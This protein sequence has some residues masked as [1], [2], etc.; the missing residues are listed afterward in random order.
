LKQKAQTDRVDIV[1]FGASGDLTSR[2]LVPALHTLASEKGLPKSVNI[3]GVGRSKF[4]DKQ[5]QN[6]LYKHLKENPRSNPNICR[7]PEFANTISYLAGSYDD[8]STYR[9]LTDKLIHLDQGFEEKGNYLFYLATPPILYS[10]IVEHLGDAGLNQSKSGW[11]RIIIEKPF[12]RD[13]QSAEDLNRQVHHVF[14]EDQVYRID[15]YLGKETVQNILAFR[16]GNAIFEPLWNRNYVDHVQITVTETVGIEHRAGYYD[17][18]GVVRD[19]FQSH[20]LQLVTIIAM[21]PPAAMKERELRDEKVKVLQNLRLAALDD[22]VLGQYRG[23]VNEPGVSQSSKTPTYVS[24]KLYIDNWRWQGVPFYLR[25]GKALAQKATEVILQF[26]RVPSIMFP[27]NNDLN[28]N[29]IS[30]CIQPDEGHRLRFEI[31]I[32]GAGMR[33][34]PVD[35]VFHYSSKF[36]PATLPGAYERLLQ[37]AML[38]DASLFAR[39]DEIELAWAIVDPILVRAGSNPPSIYDR[40]SWGPREADELMVQDGRSWHLGSVED[41]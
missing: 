4:S 20:L 39:S 35:M 1:I 29:R 17:N 5:F 10:T 27:E 25:T 41:E 40:G 9:S 8:D 3:I 32:P 12:G 24:A 11:R 18:A 6:E 31:K 19:M 33:T 21:E 13:L 26:K 7:W 22:V 37:D 14:N 23:Y 38:A 15:H 16:F 36:G 34:T 2:K 30:I 28:P